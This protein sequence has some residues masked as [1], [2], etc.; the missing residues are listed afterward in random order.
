MPYKPVSL[1]VCIVAALLAVFTQVNNFETFLYFIGSVFAPMIAVMIAD[2]FILGKNSADKA[3]NM[4]NLILWL[5]GFVIYRLFMMTDLPL[6]NTLPAMLCTVAL[7]VFWHFI[8]GKKANVC[9]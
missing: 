9:K 1:V 8:K 3:F 2:F 6:G 4:Q 5:I 7:C